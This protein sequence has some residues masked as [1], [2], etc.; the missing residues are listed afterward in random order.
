MDKALKERKRKVY[1]RHRVEGPA[2]PAP[3]EDAGYRYSIDFNVFFKAMLGSFLVVFI[4]VF[5]LIFLY[6]A[7]H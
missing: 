6:L 7:T 1:A 2:L 4:L 5:L 3:D